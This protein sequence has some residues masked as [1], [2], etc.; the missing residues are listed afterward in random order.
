MQNPKKSEVVIT[1]NTQQPV[2]AVRAMQKELDKLEDVYTSLINAGKGGS[3]KA[4]KIKQEMDE[5]S[6]AIKVS[7]SN[8]EKA[9]QVVQNLA[10]SSLSQLNMALRAVKKE[11]GRVSSDS[12]KLDELRQKYKAINDQI[13]IMKGTLLD[14]KKGSEDWLTKAINGSVVLSPSRKTVWERP[15]NQLRNIVSKKNCLLV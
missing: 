11:M 4:K 13:S 10:S 12:P 15:A 7:R 6:G 1:V 2:A 5:L 3:E 8:M 14:V 9:Q